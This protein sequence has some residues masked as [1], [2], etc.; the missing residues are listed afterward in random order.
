MPTGFVSIADNGHWQ[1]DS[2]F[3]VLSL[4]RSGQVAS[5]QYS[6]G[7]TTNS[8]PTRVAIQVD[9]GEV[10]AL[11]STAH[12]ALGVRVGNVA[13]VYVAAPA[14]QIIEYY[15]FAPGTTGIS[16]SGLQVFNEAGQITFDSGWKLF[17]V[18][19]LLS[20]HNGTYLA[21]GR[22]YAFV[23]SQINTSILYAQILNGIPPNSFVSYLRRTSY[24]G[25]RI[26]DNYVEAALTT[27][28]VAATPPSPGGSGNAYSETY[29]NNVNP[30]SIIIDV[31]GY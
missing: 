25:V 13:Y 6:N 8:N 26:V 31:T 11:A 2:D 19:L 14:G 22:K 20:G 21:P 24:T 28:D 16:L 17:D 27:V 15:I 9:D 18:R 7:A 5:Q 29:S 10:L 12:C 30:I 1:V 3:A 23:H 4:R